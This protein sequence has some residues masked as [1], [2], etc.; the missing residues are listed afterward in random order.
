MFLALT[1]AGESRKQSFNVFRVDEDPSLIFMVFF[2]PLSIYLFYLASINRSPHAR[3]VSGVWDVV[4]VLGALSGFLLVGGPAILSGLYEQWRISW[5][6]G[7]FQRLN[8][9]KGTWNEWIMLYAA[10]FVGVIFLTAWLILQARVRTSVYNVDEESLELALRRALDDGG[11]L[12]QRVGDR[13]LAL[14]GVSAAGTTPAGFNTMRPG[15]SGNATEG[16]AAP[17]GPDEDSSGVSALF[18]RPFRSLHHV[19][20]E[21]NN[22]DRDIREGIENRLA[23]QLLRFP[24][25]ANQA[26]AWFFTAG[27]MLLLFSFLTL[28]ALILFRSL[29]LGA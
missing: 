3:V 8:E 11:V 6:L 25:P 20:I 27:L 17:T 18:W 1:R 12:W 21:W 9:I 24:S 15:I 5:L 4:G 10:Y 16:A 22:V 23:E 13:K 28:G 2:L 29:R 19:G 7:N 14:F 26:A